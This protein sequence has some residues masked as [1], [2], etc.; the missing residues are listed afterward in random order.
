MSCGELPAAEEK[1]K[2]NTKLAVRVEFSSTVQTH[3]DQ[4]SL[5]TFGK[6]ILP[7][8]RMMA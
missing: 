6:G 8:G 7:E 4:R 5:C 2:I 1:G 3:E